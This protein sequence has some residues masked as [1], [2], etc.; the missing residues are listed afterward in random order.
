MFRQMEAD[1]RA[2]ATRKFKDLDEAR[3]ALLAMTPAGFRAR[4]EFFQGLPLGDDPVKLAVALAS[5]AKTHPDVV[6]REVKA[7]MARL[8]PSL[9]DFA[10]NVRSQF[11][12]AA[13][14]APAA[15]PVAAS[16]AWPSDP[17]A[18]L[19]DAKARQRPVFLVFCAAWSGAC[20]ELD[21]SLAAPS[22]EGLLAER[23]V[24]ARVDMTDE[25]APKVRELAHRFGIDGLPTLLVFD[26]S[27]RE[28][29]RHLE[30]ADAAKLKEILSRAQ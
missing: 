26:R 19:A 29:A 3:R 24:R 10:A 23:F 27:G 18:A 20:N 17:D 28:V 2:G 7:G 12:D 25:E 9:R 13:S 21:R 15:A 5:F 8:E 16:T 1:A 30:F 14:G 22:V 11:G 6:D 4:A